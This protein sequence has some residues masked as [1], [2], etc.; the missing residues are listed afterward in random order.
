MFLLFLI[1]RA[2]RGVYFGQV[3]KRAISEEALQRASDQ[4]RDRDDA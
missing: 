3:G 4:G 1:S 2:I